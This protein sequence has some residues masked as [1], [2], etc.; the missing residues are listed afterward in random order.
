MY[1]F[2]PSFAYRLGKSALAAALFCCGTLTVY[3]AKLPGTGIMGSVKSSDGKRME[4]VAVSAL[5]EGK[6]FTTSVYTNHDGEYYFPALDSGQ[7]RVWAQAVG[8]EVA[9]S[10]QTVTPSK[11]IVQN[12][13]MK[14]MAEFH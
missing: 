9:R 10:E 1:D 7:Y 3:A 2:P 4:G 11:K 6:T 12:F 8:F 14:A 5:A 13:T